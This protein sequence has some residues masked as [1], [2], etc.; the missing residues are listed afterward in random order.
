MR[1]SIAFCLLAAISVAFTSPARADHP[2]CAGLQPS[3]SATA[4]K[5][6]DGETLLLH[7]GSQLRLAGILVPRA[8]DAGADARHWPGEVAAHAELAALALGKTV[9]IAYGRERHDRYGRH[10]G[11]ALLGASEAPAER[12]WLQ[13][14]LLR[15]GLARAVTTVQNRACVQEMLALE[16]AARDG[17]RGIWTDEAYRVRDVRE[18][19]TLLA[20]RGTF[21]ILEGRITEA[22]RAGGFIRLAFAEGRRFG[23]SVT[24]PAPRGGAG[25]LVG[26]AQIP[27]PADLEGKRVRVRGWLEERGA[28]PSMDLAIVGDVEMLDPPAQ[29]R[30]EASRRPD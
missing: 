13:G 4:A 2:V 6:L 22:R 10:L 26:L 25:A 24:M 8:S 16:G 29:P 17:K 30:T 27:Q 19:D 28:R 3:F 12:V 21:Q 9:S 1:A 20:L 15:Q 14:H 23:V 18:A 5:V 11:H 7:D